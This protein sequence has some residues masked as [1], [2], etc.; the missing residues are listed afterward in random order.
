MSKISIKDGI[1]TPF[2]Y[3]KFYKCDDITKTNIPFYAE[4]T[5]YEYCSEDG[6]QHT[7]NLIKITLVCDELKLHGQFILGFEESILNF[8]I[9]DLDSFLIAENETVMLGVGFE[10]IINIYEEDLF[11]Y[12]EYC[13]PA[14]S[15]STKESC[16]GGVYFIEKHV[17]QYN[18]RKTI[19]T[20]VEC[21]IT[22][23]NKSDFDDPKEA[24]YEILN[25][26]VELWEL[27]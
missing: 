15:E 23:I 6:Q 3:L 25:D 5:I 11:N 10:N 1:Y 4:E 8:D 13:G 24:L 17:E 12:F 19:D 21:A 22:W 7:I 26:N 27:W 20:H 2:G 16:Y 14:R 9:D 18:T